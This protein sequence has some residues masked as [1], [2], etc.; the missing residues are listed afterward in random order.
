MPELETVDIKDVEIFA[1]G[2]WN[3]DSYTVEDLDEMVKGYAETFQALKPYLKLGH[4]DKQKLAQKDGYPAIG[5]VENLRR[6]GNRLVADF[7]KVPKKLAALIEAG[8]YRRVSSEIWAGLEVA[9]TKFKYLLKAVGIL[10]ADTPAV[11]N[12]DDIMALYAADVSN[13]AAYS[14]GHDVKSYEISTTELRGDVKEDAMPDIEK[15]NARIAE[16][17][18]RLREYEKEEVAEAEKVKADLAEAEKKV[19]AAEVKAVEAEKKAEQ[20]EK[21]VKAHRRQAIEVSVQATID[22]LIADK[23]IVPAQKEAAFALLLNAKDGATEKKF[24][25]GEKEMGA[26]ELVMSFF[27]NG[28]ASV[29]TDTETEAGTRSDGDDLDAK[30]RKYMES[31]QGVSYK[32]ALIEVSPAEMP[33]ALPLE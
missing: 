26:E 17:E 31:H 5:W 7:R 8:A 23:K 19:E 20:L 25:V 9:G 21:E 3:G 29:N 32:Q 28:H 14:A 6:V 4:D 13:A 12:L 33:K 27:S 10:G 11:E 1:A 24:K 15:L 16:L 2:T 30:A 18:A 22:K